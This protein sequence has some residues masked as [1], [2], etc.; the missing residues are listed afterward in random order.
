MVNVNDVI[1][2]RAPVVTTGHVVETCPGARCH[3]S[4]ISIHKHAIRIIRID[5]H[6]LVV[7][8]LR[9]VAAA[10]GAGS[11]SLSTSTATLP[12]R[13]ALRSRHV[14]PRSPGVGAHPNSELATRSVSTAGIIIRDD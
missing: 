8:V 12:E 9:I 13:P 7:P 10:G 6:A 2:D 3:P 4:V 14:A 1:S 5:S 11:N